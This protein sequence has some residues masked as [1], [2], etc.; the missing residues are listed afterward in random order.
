MVTNKAYNSLRPASYV[1]VYRVLFTRIHP[2]GD[3]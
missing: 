2:I 3:P 1:L